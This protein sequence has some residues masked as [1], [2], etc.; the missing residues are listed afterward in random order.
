M[1]QDSPEQHASA[2]PSVPDPAPVPGTDSDAPPWPKM[3]DG[4][5]TLSTDTHPTDPGTS[6]PTRT[7]DPTS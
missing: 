2:E 3:D 4:S 5:P 7:S 6:D 1:S